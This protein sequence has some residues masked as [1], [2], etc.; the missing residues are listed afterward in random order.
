[1]LLTISL[2]FVSFLS[3]TRRIEDVTR[4]SIYFS[5]NSRAPELK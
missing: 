4:G 2:P 1:L 5:N 3:S